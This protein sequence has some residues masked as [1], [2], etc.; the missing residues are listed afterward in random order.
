MLENVTILSIDEQEKKN[1]IRNFNSV[2]DYKV[3][4]LQ[5]LVINNNF[6]IIV[7]TD[8]IKTDSSIDLLVLEDDWSVIAKIIETGSKVDEITSILVLTHLKIIDYVFGQKLNKPKLV[9]FDFSIDKKMNMDK[10]SEPLYNQINLNFSKPAIIGITNYEEGNIASEITKLLRRNNHSVFQ[11]SAELWNVL[12]NI[13]RDKILIDE[14]IIENDNLK[15]YNKPR[16]FIGSSSE[17]YDLVEAIIEG[18]SKCAICVPW[19]KG[20]F[21]LSSFAIDDLIKKTDEVQYAIFVFHPSDLSLKRGKLKDSVRDNVIFECGLFVSKLG[22]RKVFFMAPDNH[23]NL[24]IPSD[25]QGMNLGNYDNNLV[26]DPVL[27]TQRF[28]IKVKNRIKE[29]FPL[30]NKPEFK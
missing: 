21:N 6:N 5:Q 4:R 10:Q 15:K 25:L 20:V 7:Y 3:E 24:D 26:D 28:C 14:L 2:P 17:G 16:V 13:F 8:Y 29:D 18:L 11:K 19:E 23:E 9:T 1:F 30:K 27:A 12:P 22:R